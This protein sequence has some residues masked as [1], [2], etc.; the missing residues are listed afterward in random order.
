MV[1]EVEPK[2]VTSSQRK[3]RPSFLKN[4]W[5]VGVL[6]FLVFWPI[7][8]VRAEDTTEQPLPEPQVTVTEESKPVFDPKEFDRNH[9]QAGVSKIEPADLYFVNLRKRNQK[10]ADEQKKKRYDFVTW[11]RTQ[12]LSDTDRNRVLQDFNKDMKQ[13][14][15]K[16]QKEIKDSL[17][18]RQKSLDKFFKEQ[19]ERKRKFTEDIQNSNLSQEEKNAKF[20][21]FNLKEQERT[22]KEFESVAKDDTLNFLGLPII[23]LGNN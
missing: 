17:L 19:K 9:P 10:F 15:D 5:G 8:H 18:K 22:Q 7:V 11:V 1:S 20:A 6:S 4:F 13:R 12:N 23:G 14:E 21:E 3:Q 2:P 16:H